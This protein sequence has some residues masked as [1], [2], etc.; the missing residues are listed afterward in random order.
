MEHADGGERVLHVDD[1]TTSFQGESLSLD[2]KCL[3]SEMR[4]I[5]HR[6]LNRTIA[7]RSGYARHLIL[8][9]NSD[10]SWR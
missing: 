1:L 2:E 7:F 5:E 8:D 6:Y 3:M 9:R 4:T 10:E